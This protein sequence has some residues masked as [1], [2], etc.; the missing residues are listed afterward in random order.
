MLIKLLTSLIPFRKLRRAARKNIRNSLADI[1]GSYLKLT[2][3]LVEEFAR[4][5][6]LIQKNTKALVIAPHPDDEAIGLGGVMAKYPKNIDCYCLN[7]SGFKRASDHLSFESIADI[8][9]KEFND[10]MD[11]LG[12]NSRKIWKIYG[13]IPH[14]DQM[15]SNLD[16]YKKTIDFSKYDLIFVPDRNDGHREHQFITHFLLPKLLLD[17]NHKCNLKIVFYG[18]WGT[19]TNPN[20]FEDISSVI[21]NKREAL[22]LY[23]SRS[24]DPLS[25]LSRVISLNNFYGL[26]TGS[27]HAEAFRVEPV[28]IYLENGLDNRWGRVK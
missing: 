7:S 20:Y 6:T 23:S 8:R 26:F 14:F 21:L 11:Y 9:I 5:D 28:H 2:D 17:S 18:V 12:V 15:M 3:S 19:V 10:C 25:L 27:T 13:D 16:T 22:K 24:Q 1:C 4:K